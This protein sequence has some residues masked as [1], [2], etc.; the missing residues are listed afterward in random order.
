M[1]YSGFLMP[2]IEN[3]NASHWLGN[4]SL[5]NN[6]NMS[7]AD[8][9]KFSRG[10]FKNFPYQTILNSTNSISTH[11]K[12][13]FL[14]WDY[15][16]KDNAPMMELAAAL[17]LTYPGIPMIYYGDE[18]GTVG[19]GTGADPYN[20]GTF[21]WNVSDWNKEMLNDY[22]KLI[23]TRKAN[24]NA[25]V[26]GAFEEVA[27]NTTDKYIVYSRY[28]N[29]DKS[30]VV[31]NNSGANSTKTITVDRLERYGFKDGDILKDVMTG[32]TATVSS[33]K[34]VLTS[35]DM[36]SAVYVLIG[37]A[38]TV[39]DVTNST[40]IGLTAE[41]DGRTKLSNVENAKIT[42]Y[43]NGVSLA[44]DDY[45][46]KGNSSNI[47][48]RAYDNNNKVVK[49]VK[50]AAT[51]KTA[52]LPDISSQDISS[53]KYTISI[54]VEANRDLSDSTVNDIYMDSD[55][56]SIGADTTA[57]TMVTATPNN[58]A[59]NVEKTSNVVFNF[60]ENIVLADNSKISVVDGAGNAVGF[61]ATV[62]GNQ[63]TVNPNEDLKEG[64]SYTVTVAC[65]CSK[66]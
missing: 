31:L 22:R 66:R 33:G 4:Q 62:S 12:P 58:A 53:G 32:N 29:N 42:N 6:G 26:Y 51:E 54:K 34:A 16:G 11:D 39:S 56:V 44:W 13:R 60:D 27:S 1:N 20:R 3:R 38:P 43:T 35:K 46:D 45:K 65:R 41:K 55:Y 28:G 25:F 14:N 48:V 61:E 21:D 19:K 18:I 30:L 59:T 36:S 50:V 10:Y 8:I 40:N 64:T 52:T 63:L 17:Q 24:I 23:A 2:F 49:E 15:T 9:G 5:D 37:N 57:P 47:I 7:V